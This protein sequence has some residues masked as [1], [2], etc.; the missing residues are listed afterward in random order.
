MP[1]PDQLY[2]AP[3]VV[4]L[5]LT[6]AIP[7]VQL[8][9]ADEPA[10]T[11]GGVLLLITFTVAVV[12]HPLAGSVTVTVYVPAAFTVG[13]DVAPPAVIPVP[14]QLYVAPVVVEFAV[15]VP[16]VVVQFND[17]DEPAVAFGTVVLLDTLTVVVAVHPFAGSV[18]VTVYVPAEFTVGDAVVPPAVIPVPAQLNV[19]PVAVEL[20]LIVP[21]VVIQL[22]INAEPDVA[23]GGVV[24]ADTI[25]V[26]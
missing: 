17:N 24:F 10:V 23:D 12:V 26:C 15:M 16:L 8:M 18:T 3:V 13:E 7:L 25:T 5:A 9:I 11:F 1:D 6:P 20:A 19:A 14:V 4:E 21:L 22:R 2:V